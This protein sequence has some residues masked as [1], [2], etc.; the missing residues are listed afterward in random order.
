MATPLAFEVR[1]AWLRRSPDASF[2]PWGLEPSLVI[3]PLAALGARLG[4]GAP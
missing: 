4:A 1:A 3:D 2:A